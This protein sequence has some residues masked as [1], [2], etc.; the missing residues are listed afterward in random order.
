MNKEQLAHM[1]EGVT[2]RKNIKL[3]EPMKFHTSF[4]IGGPA[5][6]VATPADAEEIKEILRI[7]REEGIPCYIMGNGTNLL[8]RDKGIRGVVV[9]IYDNLNKFSVKDEVIEAEAGILLSRLSNIALK[10]ELAGIEFASGIPGTLG[11]AIAMNA[12]AY[13]GEMKDVVVKTEYLDSNGELK[14]L[15]GDAHQFGYRSSLIQKENGVVLKSELQLKKG[16]MQEI[17][18][19]MDELNRRRKEKQPIHMPCAGSIFKRPVGYYTGKLIEDC[20][21]R[22][23]RIGGAE[24][25]EMHCGFIVNKGGATANDVLSLI[26]YIQ[27]EVK[28]KF[29]VELHTE[30]KVVGE[31]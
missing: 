30:V 22:G 24:V 9:K 10:S 28:S 13:G 1:I 6:I 15:L 11:G 23:Y 8:V 3:D 12:G 14:I 19:L 17:K 7:C 16:K 18:A 2:G 21:L 25:S 27:S 26:K 29:N 31:E 4:K 20:N 5:D